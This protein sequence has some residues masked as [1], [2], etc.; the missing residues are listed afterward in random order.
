M[1]NLGSVSTNEL[2][3]RRQQLR[4]QRRIKLVQV[5]WQVMAVSS[6]TGG[7]FWLINQPIWFIRQPEQIKVE[8]NQ[9]LSDQMVRSLLPLSYPESLWKIQPQALAE[10]LESR[11]QIASA[12]VTRQLFPPS[13]MI[14]IQERQPVAV[15][16]PTS[17][18]SDNR[19]NQQIGWL[20]ATGDWMPLENYTELEKSKQLPS[21]KVIGNINQYH[22]YWSLV[23]QAL[24][25]SPVKIQ[26]INWEDPN[27]L[28][29][30]TEI[31][32]VHLGPYSSKF[33]EQL[34]V[35]DRM[36]NV[37]Q[38]LDKSKMMYFDL[39][40]PNQPLV[41]MRPESTAQRTAAEEES[42]SN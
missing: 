17:N 32:T 11:G 41:Q 34:R 4:R 13:L 24:I 12:N 2:G 8:G 37:P 16:Y 23:Y 40:N 7:L 14:N 38:K 22:P 20:D 21:L 10:S 27:N 18:V 9:L 19:N 35:I 25:R 31:G 33:P 28:I 5:L 39:K 36:R 29:L 42:T 3:R 26:Q 6:L 1:T 30:E 15:A